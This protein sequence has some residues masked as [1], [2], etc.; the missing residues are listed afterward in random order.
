MWELLWVWVL[1]WES[2]WMWGDGWV[3]VWGADVRVGVGVVG[4]MAVGVGMEVCVCSAWGVGVVDVG[5]GVCEGVGWCEAWLRVR[6]PVFDA[7]FFTRPRVSAFVCVR[8]CT[9]VCYLPSMGSPTQSWCAHC[10]SPTPAAP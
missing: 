9:C 5:R 4:G 2:V 6:E 3:L 7:L 8:V 1:L 10:P